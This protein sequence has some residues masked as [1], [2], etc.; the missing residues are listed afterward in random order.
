MHALRVYLLRSTGSTWK[1]L[2]YIHVRT[3]AYFLAGAVSSLADAANGL[4]FISQSSISPIPHRMSHSRLMWQVV[5]YSEIMRLW[6]KDFDVV[7]GMFPTLKVHMLGVQ[8]ELR[9]MYKTQAARSQCLHYNRV[10]QGGHRNSVFRNA[11][12]THQI[13]ARMGICR[14]VSCACS[15]WTPPQ[16]MPSRSTTMP[17][18]QIRDAVE[19]LLPP[20]GSPGSDLKVE[21]V[22]SGEVQA[23]HEDPIPM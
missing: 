21:T 20:G 5:V 10:S 9:A 7:V 3:C 8:R 1:E 6:R 19:V 17:V 2:Q 23:I 11:I 16:V 18:S 14:R 13:G 12:T 22:S 4:Q 15:A